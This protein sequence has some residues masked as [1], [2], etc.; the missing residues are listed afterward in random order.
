LLQKGGSYLPLFTLPKRLIYRCFLSLKWALV[1]LVYAKRKD[2]KEEKNKRKQKKKRRRN[3]KNGQSNLPPGWSDRPAH[4]CLH[5]RNFQRDQPVIP[6]QPVRPAG[7]PNSRS[8]RSPPRVSFALRV[9]LPPAV[10]LAASSALT[11]SIAT[12]SAPLAPKDGPRRRSS[13]LCPHVAPLGPAP[14]RHA[15]ASFLAAARPTCKPRAA[16][17]RFFS[18]FADCAYVLPGPVIPADPPGLFLP[19]FRFE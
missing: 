15:L 7:M 6:G 18:F 11:R 16:H 19:S 5:Q 10:P 9:L 14:R 8:A 3:S 12:P 2:K 1:F 13:T 17:L 4:F